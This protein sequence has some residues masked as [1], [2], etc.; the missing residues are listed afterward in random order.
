LL[1]K[2]VDIYNKGIYECRG[3]TLNNE[4]FYAL[5]I[6]KTICKYNIFYN[7]YKAIM[8]YLTL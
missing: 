1:F 4:T 6:M 3:N 8:K 2:K 7:N 5:A